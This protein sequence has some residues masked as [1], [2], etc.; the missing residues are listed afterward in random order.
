M[1]LLEELE[2]LDIRLPEPA[3]RKAIRR[4][5]G[6]THDRIAAEL[7]VHRLTVLRWEKGTSEPGFRV[8]ARYAELLRAMER[9]AE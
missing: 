3:R 1:A 5:A 2:A 9:V 4:A 6:I 7:G 8:R